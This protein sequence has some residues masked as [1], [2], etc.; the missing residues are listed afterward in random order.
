MLVEEGERW[1]DTP[2]DE[3]P[4]PPETAEPLPAQS[5]D[6]PELFM[7]SSEQSG[8]NYALLGVGLFFGLLLFI[9]LWRFLNRDK[10]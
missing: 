10:E 7:G 4:M 9:G 3:L 8:P 6:E 2:V 5:L 1:K